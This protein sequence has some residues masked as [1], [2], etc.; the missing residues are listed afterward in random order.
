MDG[1]VELKDLAVVQLEIEQS[2]AS[3]KATALGDL[4]ETHVII[5]GKSQLPNG[6]S[7][8][9]SSHIRHCSRE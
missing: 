7:R 3:P 8:P 4:M 9:G 6:T 1:L 5:P 2:A